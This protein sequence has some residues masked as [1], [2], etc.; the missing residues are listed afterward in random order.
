[1]TDRV[2][3]SSRNTYR[4]DSLQTVDLRLSRALHLSE[5]MRLNLAVDAFDLFNRNNVDEVFSVYGAPFFVG[6]VPRHFGDGI[7]GPSGAVGAPRTV[8]NQR[9]LQLSMK[10]TF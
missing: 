10:F 2:G 1:V 8:F 6:P 3:D 9:Q 4:G 7:S 5:R